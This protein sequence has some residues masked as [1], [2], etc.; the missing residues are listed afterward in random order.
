MIRRPPRST[1]FPYT[2]LFRSRGAE[3]RVGPTE[4]RGER[5]APE[6]AAQRRLRAGGVALTQH[7]Q[8]AVEAREIGARVRRIRRDDAVDHLAAGREIAGLE[9]ELRGEE[10][11]VGRARV[12]RLGAHGLQQ[13]AARVALAPLL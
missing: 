8:P 9:R 5:G 10:Q 3:R 6:P 4:E 12:V 7:R 13:L 11:R 2:T 1:L